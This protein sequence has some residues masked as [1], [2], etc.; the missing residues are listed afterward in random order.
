MNR[1]LA[2]PWVKSDGGQTTAE[3]AVVL[4]LITLAIVTTFSVM[5]GAIQGLYEKVAGLFS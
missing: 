2:R 5:S 1:E 4:G 3:Y